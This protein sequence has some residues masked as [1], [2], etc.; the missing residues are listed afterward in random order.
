MVRREDGEFQS[1]RPRGA[2]QWGTYVPQI[3][4][5]TR[6]QALT[7][8]SALAMDRTVSP[9]LSARAELRT[10]WFLPVFMELG[11]SASKLGVL[12]NRQ[13][14]WPLHAP[15]AAPNS[16]LDNRTSDYPPQVQRSLVAWL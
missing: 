11:V 6:L 1:T 4:S 15:L 2:R 13:R 3:V 7:L 8:L 16:I 12:S 14:A 10:I 9:L 5:L